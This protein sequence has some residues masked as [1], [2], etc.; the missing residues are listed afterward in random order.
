MLWEE[1]C[2]CDSVDLEELTGILKSVKGSEF[3]KVFGQYVEALLPLWGTVTGDESY[4]ILSMIVDLQTT[5]S[6]R[7]ANLAIEALKKRYGE[8]KDFQ[9]K[10][11]IVGLRT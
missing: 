8:D 9:D 6:P 7:L 4:A 2:T 5:N 1:Y 11:R 3:A 10:L